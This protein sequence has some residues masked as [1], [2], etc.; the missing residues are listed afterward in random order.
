MPQTND[1]TITDL[2]KTYNTRSGDVFAV[3]GL[4]LSVPRGSVFGFLGPN[5]AGKTTT[6]KMIVGLAE[7]TGGEIAILGGKPTD[8]S[9]RARIGFMPESPAFY[10][11]LSGREFLELVAA[12]FEMKDPKAR[13][14]DVLRQ[15]DLFDRAERHIRTFSKGMLQRLGLA[16]ALLNDPEI[17]FLDEPLDGLDPLGR[18]EIKEIIV[19]QKKVGKT[20]FF[21]SHILADVEEV[22]DTVGII[23]NGH[24]VACDTPAVLSRG[25]RDLEDAFVHIIKERRATATGESK[26][27]ESTNGQ[28]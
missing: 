1:I 15:V 20:V 24:L 22:C 8:I 27:A 3:S 25:Y 17:L 13:I 4:T 28:K 16:Q 18:A 5:G 19:A 26:S 6:I 7:P 2:S 12:I 10:M 11:Y 9:V 14:D 21:N 23:D